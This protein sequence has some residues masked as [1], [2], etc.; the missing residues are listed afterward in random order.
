MPTFDELNVKFEAAGLHF[1]S[2]AFV[3]VAVVVA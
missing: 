1:L 2:G 3:A